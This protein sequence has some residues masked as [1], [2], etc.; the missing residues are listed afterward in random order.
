MI[1]RK[2]YN[3]ISYSISIVGSLQDGKYRGC[4]VNS[5]QQLTSSSPAKFA[6]TLNKY[7]L[8]EAAVEQTG[9]FCATVA[10]AD[11]PHDIINLFG[12]K[13]GRITDKFAAYD[14][15]TDDAGCPYITDGMC[16]R[17]SFRVVQQVDLDSAVLFIAEV[18]EAEILKDG[19]ALTVHSKTQA[20]RCRPTRRFTA[21]W[22]STTA[23]AAR[24]AA[25]CT[26]RTPC[27]M[28][29]AVLCASSP[30]VSLKSCKHSNFYFPA[31]ADA[32][33]LLLRSLLL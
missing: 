10:A 26:S 11:C 21:R 14:T 33:R 1:D 9:A 8:T 19:G 13:S 29:S 28:T 12:Y 23:T 16:A 27:R 24:S 17:L 5:L 20:K 32:K 22:M 2:A 6:V 30:Q 31:S 25:T 18:T 15:K 4:V 7:N 3:S